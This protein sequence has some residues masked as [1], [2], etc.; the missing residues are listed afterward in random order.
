MKQTKII[1]L[2]SNTMFKE[3]FGKEENKNILS[4]LLSTYLELDYDYVFNNVKH[5]NNKLKIVNK[6]D[7]K[8]DVD[9]IIR[10]NNSII[11]NLEM[12]ND[13]WKGINNRNFGY[14]SQMYASQFISGASKNDFKNAIKHIQ[15]NFNNFNFPKDKER[16]I[17]RLK[18]IETG[19]ELT[20]MIE[21]HSINLEMINKKCYNQVDE[22]N[23]VEK[24]GK[25][26]KSESID[27]IEEIVGEEMKDIIDKIVELSSDENLVGLYNKEDLQRQINEGIVLDA[28]E[29]GISKGT[30]KR[31]I[32]IA[33]KML[34]EKMK[35]DT[36]SK[37]TGLSIEEIKK[38]Q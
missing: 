25:L 34:E 5:I 10:I 19:E 31:N 36:I 33:K 18:D 12:N 22:L 20:D 6:N 35:I 32:E 7:Y 37:I 21:I 4:Y 26:L 2:T 29:R 28:E 9:V 38:L 24:I 14:I 23:N 15:I 30:S 3:L 11:G 1:P 16:S 27:E 8:Y 17:Y 13:N